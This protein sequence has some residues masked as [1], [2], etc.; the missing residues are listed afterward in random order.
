MKYLV[1][2]VETYRI[3]SEKEA[4]E[5]IEDAKR[6]PNFTLVKYSNEQKERKEK[7]EVVDE[8]RRV[9]LWKSFNDEKDPVVEV[10]VDY[11][12]R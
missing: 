9:T 6:S 11:E 4:T 10:K 5:F 8:W 3:D 1:N 12:V 2:V 7:G